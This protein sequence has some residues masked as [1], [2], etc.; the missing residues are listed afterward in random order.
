MSH[1]C[2]TVLP[3][4][5]R[6]PAASHCSSSI[7]AARASGL[8]MG[9]HAEQSLTLEF[10]MEKESCL[11]SPGFSACTLQQMLT[12][13]A[14]DEVRC[15]V[16]CPWGSHSGCL[17]EVLL[18]EV[19]FDLPGVQAGV[20]L[21]RLLQALRQ[22][23]WPAEEHTNHRPAHSMGTSAPGKGLRE[24]GCSQH[25]E[26]PALLSPGVCC[27]HRCELTVPHRP[28]K[29]GFVP[30]PCHR[31]HSSVEAQRHVVG[32]GRAGAVRTLPPPLSPLTVPRHGGASN[33]D[34]HQTPLPVSH[35]H[36]SPGPPHVPP[37]PMVNSQCW[38]P[39]Q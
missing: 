23:P 35:C 30:E 19:E 4:L 3:S 16:P 2:P 38:C 14:E 26:P 21:A 6:A 10:L 32:L 28:P 39:S 12:P 8:S 24:D 18:V 33:A 37:L 34:A 15:V 11:V 9:V 7:T 20:L 17:L 5:L 25:P 13:G 22:G 29:D 36:G 27:S 31:V 1:P